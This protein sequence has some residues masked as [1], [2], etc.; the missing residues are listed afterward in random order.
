MAKPTINK[1]WGEGTNNKYVLT[2]DAV[3]SGIALKSDVVS[4][5][6]NSIGNRIE[7]FVDNLQ[8]VTAWNVGKV[9]NI[10]DMVEVLISFTN[11]KQTSQLL[12]ATFISTLDNNLNEPLTQNTATTFTRDDNYAIPL[13]NLTVANDTSSIKDFINTG[14]NY[15]YNS[16]LTE[17][18]LK[19]ETKE[20]IAGTATFSG[21]VTIDGELNANANA[22]I[23]GTTTFNALATG[24]TP[25][26]SANGNELV[27][28]EWVIN[29]MENG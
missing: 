3:N 6:L 18:A 4:N 8:R 26:A 7:T 24:T 13:Y 20:L 22:N 14:W 27:T 11:T 29:F 15:A 25:P 28:A 12:K 23:N 5:Q 1:I 2:E 10:G 19:T 17:L 16:N 9:Y 21:N